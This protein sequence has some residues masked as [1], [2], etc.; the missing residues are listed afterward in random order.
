[1]GAFWIIVGGV[2]GGRGGGGERHTHTRHCHGRTPQPKSTHPQTPTPTCCARTRVSPQKREDEAGKPPPPLPLSHPAAAATVAPRR[3]WW[4]G[5][6][7]PPAPHAPPAPPPPPPADSILSRLGR[8]FLALWPAVAP[9]VCPSFWGGGGEWGR[10][11]KRRFVCMMRKASIDRVM[12]PCGTTLAPPGQHK[13]IHTL[14]HHAMAPCCGRVGPRGAIAQ[15]QECGR[16]VESARFVC[17]CVCW[18][19]GC[20][21]VSKRPHRCGAAWARPFNPPIDRFRCPRAHSRMNEKAI[22]ACHTALGTHP[23]KHP[24]PSIDRSLTPHLSRLLPPA[25]FAF[26]RQRTN[27]LALAT[28]AARS[29]G[30]CWA[31]PSPLSPTTAACAIDRFDPQTDPRSIEGRGAGRI[32][33]SMDGSCP[34]NNEHLSVADDQQQPPPPPTVWVE[35]DEARKQ[36]VASQLQQRCI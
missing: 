22:G 19:C 21:R 11:D 7:A 9:C 35:D 33:A 25:C 29:F 24:K 28:A 3:A 23:S 30:A 2:G 34:S 14:H 16:R 10:F 13:P 27:T 32:L 20:V 6:G 5:C 17:C 18:C 26:A 8:R 36:R 12:N 4:P 31:D 15:Q 1:M